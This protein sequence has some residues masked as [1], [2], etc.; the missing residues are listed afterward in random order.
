VSDRFGNNNNSVVAE[1]YVTLDA[2]ATYSWRK[3]HFTLRGRNLLD[4]DYESVAGTTIRR[5]ADPRTAEFSTRVS[6]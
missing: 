4:E 3:W 6:F 5:L 1:E 2:A